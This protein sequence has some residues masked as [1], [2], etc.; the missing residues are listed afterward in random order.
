MHARYGRDNLGGM[1]E[2]FGE[3]DIT[4]MALIGTIPETIGSKFN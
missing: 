3:S 2:G 1:K 4:H